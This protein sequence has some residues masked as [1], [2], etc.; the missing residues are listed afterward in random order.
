MVDYEQ[1]LIIFRTFADV[2][3]LKTRTTNDKR[4]T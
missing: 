2:E 4:D 1:F 3:I